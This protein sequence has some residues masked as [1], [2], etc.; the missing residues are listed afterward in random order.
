M[1]FCWDLGGQGEIQD[2][3]QVSDLQRRLSP[4]CNPQTEN[5][6]PEINE[7]EILF[8]SLRNV[9]SARS[10]EKRPFSQATYSTTL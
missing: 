2:R 6:T 10:E 3:S 5:L 1:C 8:N 9:L 4:R 7:A